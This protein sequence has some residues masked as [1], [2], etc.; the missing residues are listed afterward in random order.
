[1]WVLQNDL[2]S[3][4]EWAKEWHLSFKCVHGGAVK[5]EGLGSSSTVHSFSI[6][7][8]LCV[9]SSGAHTEIIYFSAECGE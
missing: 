2:D 7:C 5:T 9:Q 8:N 3:I 4:G 1:V 6:Y